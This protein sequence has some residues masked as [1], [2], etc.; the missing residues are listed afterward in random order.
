MV[1]HEKESGG[2]SYGKKNP[3]YCRVLKGVY[4]IAAWAAIGGKNDIREYYEY[5]LTEKYYPET[6][7]IN[8][9]ARYIAK[10]SLAIM[11][12]KQSYQPYKWR[13]EKNEVQPETDQS[14]LRH[15]HKNKKGTQ[16]KTT[17][18]TYSRGYAYPLAGCSPAEP[19]YV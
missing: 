16:S 18:S 5:L 9:I 2:K 6:R 12:N 3:R 14:F 1:K 17:V 4:R 10:V 11:R 19:T 15:C 8:Q 7:A 13:L